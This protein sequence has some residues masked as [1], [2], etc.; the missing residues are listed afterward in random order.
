MELLAT[1]YRNLTKLK[2][3]ILGELTFEDSNSV[4]V[5]KI[6]DEDDM[7][8]DDASALPTQQSVKTYV[9][10]EIADNKGADYTSA[11]IDPVSGYNIYTAVNHGLGA[12]P[13]LVEL[14]LVCKIAQHGYSVGDEF[15]CMFISGVGGG[16]PMKN[17]TQIQIIQHSNPG[18]YARSDG[19]LTGITNANWKYKIRAWK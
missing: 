11:E 10:D 5:T 4:T 3:L 6:L 17:A 13:S 14:V 19:T 12:V 1:L 9:D 18:V 7:S 8:S 15:P 16:F 2:K